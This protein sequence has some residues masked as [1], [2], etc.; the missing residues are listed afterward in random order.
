MPIP[1]GVPEGEGEYPGTG[2][3]VGALGGWS[4]A[5]NPNTQRADAAAEFLEALTSSSFQQENFGIAGHIPPVPGTLSEATD[6]P[7]MGRYV[8]TLSYVGEHTMSRPATVV[9]SQQSQFVAQQANQALQ[10]G[11]VEGAMSTLADQLQQVENDY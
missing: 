3:S 7:I 9:W 2:G 6:V 11:D 10:Q 4:Y 8:D 1:Y 5:V